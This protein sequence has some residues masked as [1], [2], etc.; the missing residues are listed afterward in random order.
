[1]QHKAEG[2]QTV[3]L[4]LVYRRIT[5]NENSPGIRRNPGEINDHRPGEIRETEFGLPP[6]KYEGRF[7]KRRRPSLFISTR[8]RDRKA[9]EK[10]FLRFR[11][12]CWRDETF[13]RGACRNRDR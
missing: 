9:D 4:I 2:G 7:R 5:A 12:P 3:R 11:R 6:S 1:M 8:R 13:C 10:L